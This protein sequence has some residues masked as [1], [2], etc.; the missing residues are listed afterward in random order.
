MEITEVR[1][2]LVDDPLLTN[3]QEIPLLGAYRVDNE[4]VPGQTVTLIEN[5]V[6]KDLLMTRTPRKG[7]DKSNGHARSALPGMGGASPSNLV[8]TGSRPLVTRDMR[9]RLL[10]EIRKEK[11]HYG[12]IVQLLPARIDAEAPCMCRMAPVIR[13]VTPDGKEQ[14]VRGASFEALNTRVLERVVAVGQAA[15]VHNEVRLNPLQPGFS[16]VAP[17]LL[18]NRV[19]VKKPQGP[20]PKLPVVSRPLRE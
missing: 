20:Q 12:M 11:A 6:L 13:R 4:G 7:H 17:P 19:V 10:T 3:H 15:T 14:L 8:F 5:G 16:V 2:R 9:K 1:I 18:V